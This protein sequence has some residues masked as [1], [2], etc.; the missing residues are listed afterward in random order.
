MT[1][2]W[3]E[4]GDLCIEVRGKV[5]AA[6]G[7][8]RV[9]AQKAYEAIVDCGP[10]SWEDSEQGRQAVEGYIKGMLKRPGMYTG[11][12][13]IQPFEMLLLNVLNVWALA[14]DRSHIDIKAVLRQTYQ[15]M[16]GESCGAGSGVQVHRGVG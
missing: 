2:M 6:Q 3:M 4:A 13:L 7:T 11:S 10:H 12:M 1:E 8:I 14:F 9:S 15:R 16:Y 5:P